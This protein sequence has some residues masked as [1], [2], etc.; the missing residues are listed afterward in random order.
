MNEIP[1]LA[2]T[3]SLIIRA[4]R[5][6]TQVRRRE[7]QLSSLEDELVA[8]HDHLLEGTS[9]TDAGRDRLWFALDAISAI[10]D[11]ERKGG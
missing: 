2:M 1:H 8:L 7:R 3:G 6:L 9:L 5:L 10:E 4:S 11:E